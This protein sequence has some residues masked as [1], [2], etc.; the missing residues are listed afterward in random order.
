MQFQ[1]FSEIRRLIDAV[2]TKESASMANAVAVLTKAVLEKHAVYV[3]GASHAGILTQEMFYRAGGLVVINPI[4]GR[5]VMLD[6][7]PITHTSKMER[8][9]GYGTLLAQKTPMRAGDVLIVHSVS[10]RNPVTIEVALEAKKRN[11]TVICI[12][13]LRYSKSVTSRHPSGKK[14]Y[15][16][17]DIVID[18]H[19]E[20]GDACVAIKGIKQ[21]VSPTST[22]I[23]ASILNSIV[24]ATAQA[25]VDAG[26]KTPPIFY[27]ANVDGGDEL[28]RKIYEE[29]KQNI[30]YSY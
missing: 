24:A 25:L 6:T 19:G 16:V 26:L 2:E 30:H 23:G 14:L 5:E 22:V 15:E 8:L 20:K 1:Y 28:N 18:N 7:F 4:F 29:Y 9:V 27:S 12:T 17:S 13:N 10:G 11:T 3:F 21:K